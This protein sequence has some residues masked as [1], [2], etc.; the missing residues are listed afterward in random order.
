MCISPLGAAAAPGTLLVMMLLRLV[1]LALFSMAWDENVVALPVGL[2]IEHE[3]TDADAD[4]DD[5][6]ALRVEYLGIGRIERYGIVAAVR[7]RPAHGRLGPPANRRPISAR[8]IGDAGRG[9]ALGARA[10]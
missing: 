4:D 3:A 1:E 9:D 5:G 6:R 10:G 2:G 8:C 7:H